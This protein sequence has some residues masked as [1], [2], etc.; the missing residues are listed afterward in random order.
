LEFSSEDYI[1]AGALLSVGIVN[2]G[3][4]H[5]VRCGCSVVD[6]VFDSVRFLVS[7][8]VSQRSIRRLHCSAST[9][10]DDEEKKTQR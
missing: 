6:V 3:V 10:N 5:E 4:R 9:D 1:K 8:V 7:F 2:S